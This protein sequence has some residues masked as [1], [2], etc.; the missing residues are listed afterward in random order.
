[1]GPVGTLFESDKPIAGDTTLP[2]LMFA[3]DGVVRDL[4][5]C[6]LVLA[7]SLALRID[8][9]LAVFLGECPFLWLRKNVERGLGGPAQLHA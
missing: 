9:L 6:E 8:D 7:D 5:L 3:S 4:S 2:R 1:M